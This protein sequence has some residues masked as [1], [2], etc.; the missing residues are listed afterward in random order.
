MLR[1]K[2]NLLKGEGKKVYDFTTLSGI[3]RLQWQRGCRRAEEGREEAEERG[4]E[5]T[6]RELCNEALAGERTAVMNKAFL[7]KQ[8]SLA[9]TRKHNARQRQRM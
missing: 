2:L 5:M 7:Q 9:E 6:H 8:N 4:E 3:D 1:S